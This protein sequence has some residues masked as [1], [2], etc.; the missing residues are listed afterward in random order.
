MSRKESNSF[1][2]PSPQVSHARDVLNEVCTDISHLNHCKLSFY[3]G[4]FDTYEKLYAQN[5]AL[6]EKQ[7]EKKAAEAAHMQAFVDKFR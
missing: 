5:K 1:P 6:L 7:H 3:K 4:D 2:L